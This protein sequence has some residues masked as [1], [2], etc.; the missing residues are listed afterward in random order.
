MCWGTCSWSWLEWKCRTTI[1]QCEKNV[2]SRRK[3]CTHSKQTSKYVQENT[4]EYQINNKNHTGSRAKWSLF[5]TIYNEEVHGSGG[6]E[7]VEPHVIGASH[8]GWW[9]NHWRGSQML[10]ALRNA[11]TETTL[12]VYG[13]SGG[14]WGQILILPST[15]QVS[16]NFPS[17]DKVHKVRNARQPAARDSVQN[18]KQRGWML[19]FETHRQLLLPHL[20]L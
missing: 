1:Q 11:S 13:S 12:A 17:E 3:Y 10:P 20:P 16:N 9:G 2:R 15:P 4:E 19:F 8:L 6:G 18:R 5:L 14:I 7:Q